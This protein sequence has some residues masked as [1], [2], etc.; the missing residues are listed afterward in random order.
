MFDEFL[1][2][3]EWK[4]TD[5]D[6][7]YDWRLIRKVWIY[8]YPV[9]AVTQIFCPQVKQS[10]RTLRAKNDARGVLGILETC[11]RNNFAG[12][13]SPRFAVH[14][15]E[16]LFSLTRPRLYSEVRASLA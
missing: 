6:P 9:I 7:F 13:E 1:Y 12:V 5:E 16:C 15:H 2:F 8:C 3:D 14:D 4:R 10:L 11:I